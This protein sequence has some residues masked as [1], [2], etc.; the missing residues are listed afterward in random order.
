MAKKEKRG[1]RGC[2][3]SIDNSDTGSRMPLRFMYTDYDYYY[4]YTDITRCT[5]IY[6]L[7]GPTDFGDSSSKLK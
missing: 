7:V 2:E 6:E 1:R 4:C 5:I 3:R